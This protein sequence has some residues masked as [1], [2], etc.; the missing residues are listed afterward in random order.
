MNGQA[1]VAV[2]KDLYNFLLFSLGFQPKRKTNFSR[3]LLAANRQDINNLIALTTTEGLVEKQKPQTR[4]VVTYNNVHNEQ[5]LTVAYAAKN[6]T[7]VYVRPTVFYDGILRELEYA[8]L[9]SLIQYEGRFVKVKLNDAVVGWILKDDLTLKPEEVIPIFVS[10]R[11]YSSYDQET[12]KLREYISDNFNASEIFL[13]LQAEELVTYRL[14]QKSL[15]ID[16][17]VTRPRTAGTWQ[18]ILKGLHNI[19]IS[20]EPKTG[21]I[22]EFTNTAGIGFIGYTT[23]VLVDESIRFEGVGMNIEGEY[24]EELVPKNIWLEWRPIWMTVS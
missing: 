3:P 2:L 11:V 7:K 1:L 23:T 16:W 5:F 15:K 10:G 13:P 4:S 20:I 19:K 9:V 18:S 22:I 17:P 12:V 21:S 24:L 14:K 6:R 8:T